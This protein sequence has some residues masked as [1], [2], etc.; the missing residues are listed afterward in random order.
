[1]K[2]KDDVST[3]I[4]KTDAINDDERELHIAIEPIMMATRE[5]LEEASFGHRHNEEEL[6]H[7]QA[8]I[9]KWIGQTNLLIGLLACLLIIILTLL[10]VR[11]RSRHPGFIEVDVYNPEDKLVSG[12]QASG[13]ENPTYTFYETK[14]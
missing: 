12:M 8:Y 13:Y 9:H 2:S 11:R 6:Q 3:T 10:F 5:E 1:M 4:K 7:E 14:P